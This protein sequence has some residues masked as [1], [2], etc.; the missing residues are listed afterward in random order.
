MLAKL[1][2]RPADGVKGR[3][4]KL[5]H[6]IDLC[7]KYLHKFPEASELVKYIRVEADVP[8][9]LKDKVLEKIKAIG[10]KP[11]SVYMNPTTSERFC[12]I[13]K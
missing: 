12:T 4:I 13:K 10:W 6:Y 9:N 5:A 8:P 7:E 1:C 3:S 11:R 2:F